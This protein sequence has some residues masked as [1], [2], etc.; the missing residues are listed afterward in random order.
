MHTE[1]PRTRRSPVVRERRSMTE[2]L[3]ERWAGLMANVD[4][5]V[6]CCENQHKPVNGYIFTNTGCKIHGVQSNYLR[7]GEGREDMRNTGTKRNTAHRPEG[8]SR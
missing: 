6:C 5:R 4:T 7:A 8:A 1:V 2:N 3:D